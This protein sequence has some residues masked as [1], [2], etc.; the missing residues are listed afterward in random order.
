MPK[1][2]Q[3]LK[4]V[5]SEYPITRVDFNDLPFDSLSSGFVPL[6]LRLNL[7]ESLYYSKEYFV[8]VLEP[9]E[10]RFE[11]DIPQEC[12]IASLPVYYAMIRWACVHCENTDSFFYN[13]A[14]ALKSLFSE[15]LKKGIVL[16]GSTAELS[17]LDHDLSRQTSSNH[18]QIVHP[19][20]KGQA[21]SNTRFYDPDDKQDNLAS[22][23]FF[24]ELYSGPSYKKTLSWAFDDMDYDVKSSEFFDGAK[25]SIAF[26]SSAVRPCIT[27][28]PHGSHGMIIPI[29]AIEQRI[30]DEEERKKEKLSVQ[31][32][33]RI[34]LTL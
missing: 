31:K 12:V 29:Y 4:I 19:L 7:A 6:E 24:L 30:S 20:L 2:V 13:T 15:T 10:F 32:G 1:K 34:S 5:S 14:V 27:L 22:A 9:R 11:D 26:G 3:E 21:W 17:K 28:V 8:R 25:Y 33:K 23:L 18:L 16:T